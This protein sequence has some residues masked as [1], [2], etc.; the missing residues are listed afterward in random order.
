MQ[1]L[2][3]KNAS[4]VLQLYHKQVEIDAKQKRI[5]ELESMQGVSQMKAEIDVKQRRIEELESSNSVWQQRIEKERNHVS[6]QYKGLQEKYNREVEIRKQ[7][8]ER[9]KAL[10]AKPS[11]KSRSQNRGRGRALGHLHVNSNPN[12]NFN[13]NQPRNLGPERDFGPLQR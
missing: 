12:V 5:E 11:R 10:E 9:L 3:D 4:S 13:I 7:L 1:L 2:S 8:E 6:E